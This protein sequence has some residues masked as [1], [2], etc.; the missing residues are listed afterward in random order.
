VDA[1]IAE[2]VS[3]RPWPQCDDIT[4]L[5]DEDVMVLDVAA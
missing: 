1:F 4:A 2:L 3:S 5:V